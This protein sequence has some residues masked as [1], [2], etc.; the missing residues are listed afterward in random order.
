MGLRS[1]GFLLPSSNGVWGKVN[2]FTC[3]CHSVH[4]V[5]CFPSIHHCK[6]RGLRGRRGLH[7]GGGCIHLIGGESALGSSAD[8]SSTDTWD[9]TGQQAGGRSYWNAFLL[10]HYICVDTDY[11]R[12][13]SEASEGY[14]FT[15]VCHTFCSTGGGRWATTNGQP[16][17]PPGPGQNIYPPQ[18]QVRTSIPSPPPGPGQN[19]YT[20]SHPPPGPGQNIY[21]LRPPPLP[22]TRSEHIPPPPR[23]QVRTSTPFPPP[24]RLH[25][26]GR[27]A[28]YWNAFLY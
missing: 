27:Y 7:P 19:I 17:P 21:P 10:L 11:Y 2:V 18:D 5:G 4:G 24:P 12:P 15:G 20:P 28:S 6:R 1:K 23:D 9:T 16:L 13:R 25:A 8:P 22:G 14:V 3:M 26:G